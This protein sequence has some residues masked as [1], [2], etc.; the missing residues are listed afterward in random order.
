MERLAG[1]L[2]HARGTVLIDHVGQDRRQAGSPRGPGADRPSCPGSCSASRRRGNGSRSRTDTLADSGPEVARRH[3]VGPAQRADQAAPQAGG[4]EDRVDKQSGDGLTEGPRHAQGHQAL[5]GIAGQGLA[6][7]GV[8]GPG[9][10]HNHLK[11]ARLRAGTLHNHARGAPVEG[12]THEGVAVVA[13]VADRDED[14]AR[15]EP[16]M[17]VGAAGDLPVGAAH[18]L[19]FGQQPA[20]AH[21]GNPPLRQT[22]NEPAC[23]RHTPPCL[24]SRISLHI[25]Q[26]LARNRRESISAWHRAPRAPWIA[27]H[28]SSGQNRRGRDS[29]IIALS[30][31]G[32]ID[33]PVLRFRNLV[34]S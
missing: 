22:V 23:H 16:A 34:S 5:R 19:G 21:R 14:L 28:S 30:P 11:P 29:G 4:L 32:P 26:R 3:A 25:P 12:F 13:H 1:D 2:D 8:G 24:A 20:Q 31:R 17:I 6:N 33:R 9:V 27:G 7:Q 18:E 10:V 15:V